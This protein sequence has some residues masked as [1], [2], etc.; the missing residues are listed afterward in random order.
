M[1]A[2][3]IKLI[4]ENM[5]RQGMHKHQADPR[6]AHLWRARPPPAASG[7]ARGAAWLAHCTP[8]AEMRRGPATKTGSAVIGGCACGSLTANPEGP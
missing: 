3:P 4:A 6:H 5:C 7:V 2:H 1:S 8:I